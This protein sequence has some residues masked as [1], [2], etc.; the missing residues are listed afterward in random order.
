MSTRIG[1]DVGGTNTDAVLMDGERVLG[2]VKTPTTADVT[3]GI[4]T[5]LSRLVVDSHVQPA[6]VMAVVASIEG[7]GGSEKTAP[8]PTIQVQG[9]FPTA[10]KDSKQ[11]ERRGGS[12]D[13]SGF[14][15]ARPRRLGG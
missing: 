15:A 10:P 2:E 12:G 3:S 14:H 13:P 9:A 7:C 6:R 4:V 11:R 1:I 8:V 5:A